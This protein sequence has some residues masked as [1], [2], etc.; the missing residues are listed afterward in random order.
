MIAIL[1][2][3]STFYFCK[4]LPNYLP[5]WL[6]HFVF[7]STMNRIPCFMSPAAFGVVFWI[8][9]IVISVVVV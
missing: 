9:A 1:Y 2:G 6:F 3:K 5:E 8:L 4:Q 7:P